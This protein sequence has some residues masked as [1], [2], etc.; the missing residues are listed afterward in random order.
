VYL[1]GQV[2]LGWPKGLNEDE[3]LVAVCI[4]RLEDPIASKLSIWSSENI[5]AAMEH[6]S[7]R[8]STAYR[9][10]IDETVS[11]GLNV[12]ATTRNAKDIGLCLPIRVGYGHLKAE[13]YRLRR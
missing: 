9:A 1:T 6:L 3:Q 8:V 2:E 12:H 5:V 13:V 7:M 4:R 10:K 11:F